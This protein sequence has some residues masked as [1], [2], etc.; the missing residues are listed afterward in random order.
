MGERKLS[1]ANAETLKE[2]LGVEAGAVSPFGLLNDESEGVEVYMDK[3][4]Y[5]APLVH[6][7][8]NRNT[9]SLELT[10]EMFQCYLGSAE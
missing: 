3:E 7:H 10:G 9:A 6:F 5:E 2:R 1:F 4:A 8:P